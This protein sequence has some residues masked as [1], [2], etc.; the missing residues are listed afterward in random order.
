MFSFDTVCVC[1]C[2]CAY[3]CVHTVCCVCVCVHACACT[4]VCACMCACMNVCACVCICVGEHACVGLWGSHGLMVARV[5]KSWCLQEFWSDACKSLEVCKSLDATACNLLPEMLAT[6]LKPASVPP[7]LFLSFLQQSWC[8]QVQFF[9]EAS[10]SN[11]LSNLSAFLLLTHMCQMYHTWALTCVRKV[12]LW[13]SFTA[14]TIY[15]IFDLF[16]YT[17][18]DYFRCWWVIVLIPSNPLLHTRNTKKDSI[19]SKTF[20]SNLI[21]C[22]MYPL[23]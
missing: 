3:L 20:W 5:L 13:K 14:S 21:L 9:V 4:G 23:V 6:I 12:L 19:Q 1:I 15:L 16:W 2:V 22:N 17:L 7:T 8:F 18:E 11:C 10:A